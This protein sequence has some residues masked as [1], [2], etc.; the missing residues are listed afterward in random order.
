MK[1]ENDLIVWET[2]K[3][4]Y[5]QNYDIGKK[6]NAEQKKQGCCIQTSKISSLMETSQ[7]FGLLLV[8]DFNTITQCIHIF[9]IS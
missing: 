2:N 3:E 6:K 5:L 7:M 9:Y 8:G 1:F 4:A